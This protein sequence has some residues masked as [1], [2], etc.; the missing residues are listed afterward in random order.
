MWGGTI[1]IIRDHS[2][3]GT[4]LA[5]W[6]WFFPKYQDPRLHGHPD[7]PHNDILNLVSDYGIIGFGLMAWILVVFFF[8][9]R[10]IAQS[11]P[12]SEQSAF[13]IGAMT[14]V[15]SILVHS[16]FD[17]NL[18]IPANSL[19]LSAIMG[20]TMSMTEE[21]RSVV[22]RPTSIW[23]RLS[24]VLAMLVACAVAVWSYVPAI[25]AWR[26]ADLASNSKKDLDY[27]SALK[28]AEMAIVSDPKYVIPHVLIGDINKSIAEWRR[29][30]GKRAERL[31]YA[32][33]AV[34]SYDR[35]L[36]LNP[37]HHYCWLSK[38]KAYLLAEKDDLALEGIQCAIQLAPTH[39][40]SHFTLGTIYRDRGE[41]RLAQE[42]FSRAVTL[43]DSEVM[44]QWN[45]YDS[46]QELKTPPP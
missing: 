26:Y 34:A 29:G 41:D 37:R 19:L 15:V 33:K 2:L 42:S 44:L 40:D 4:G 39:A 25:R 43:E 12:G 28:F 23:G 21:R 6:Q 45:L 13:A 24:L 38:G 35:A 27:T 5:S 31:E 30:P 32:L 14:S 7:Y 17:F 1:G 16:W 46:K 22:V 36:A 8:C 18:H 20:F 9:A 11:K 3:W 10:R